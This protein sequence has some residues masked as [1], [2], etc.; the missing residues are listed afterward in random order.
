MGKKQKIKKL[1]S[2]VGK[3]LSTSEIEKI[4]RKT[5]VGGGIASIAK[6]QGINVKQPKSAPEYS[7]GDF[8]EGFIPAEFDYQSALNLVNAQGNIDTQIANLNADA[9]KEVERIRGKSAVDVAGI[10]AG[11]S[12][13]QADRALES[14]L[15]V[16]NIRAKGAVDVAGIEA[17]ATRYQADRALESAL[18]VEN[19]RAKGA[20]DLQG[21]VNAGLE[22]VENIRGEYGLKGKMID[23]GT[24]IYAGLVN[25]FNFS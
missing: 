20:I 7:Y 18:G 8:G 10:E 25:A 11:A 12:R 14:A 6:K 2:K 17:G 4:K 5:G 19:I 9:A 13:Y 23:R 16:E 15:G 1:L 22:R 3:K 24:S 21:I